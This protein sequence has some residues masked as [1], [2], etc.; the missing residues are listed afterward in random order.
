LKGEED[1]LKTGV[2]IGFMLVCVAGLLFSW[3]VTKS[4]AISFPDTY[5]H[6]LDTNSGQQGIDRIGANPPFEIYGHDWLTS[7]DNIL[8]IW[9]SW[10]LGLDGKALFDTQLGDVFIYAATGTIAVALRDHNPGLGE[11]NFQAGDLFE[12]TMML[13]SDHYYDPDTGQ[14]HKLSYSNYGD[15]E[16]VLAS[17]GDFRENLG[18]SAIGYGPSEGKYAITIEFPTTYDFTM[19]P[20]IRFAYTC[21]NDIHHVPEPATL[22]LFGTGLTG[23]AGFRR[24][25]RE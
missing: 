21:G 19:H 5:L 1:R 25:F 15:H 17:E 12:P 6:P 14:L 10:H 3:N 16:I 9:T 11:G 23:L 4:E 13:T 8:R 22:L 7:G 2:K 18:A 24:K 20:G